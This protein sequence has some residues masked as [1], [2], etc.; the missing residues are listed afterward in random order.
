VEKTWQSEAILVC[1]CNVK[2]LVF[3]HILRFVCWLFVSQKCWGCIAS[4]GHLEHGLFTVQ[5]ILCWLC[6]HE[7]GTCGKNYGLPQN[8]C[9]QSNR[10]PCL[11]KSLLG[12][13]HVCPTCLLAKM[14]R[15]SFLGWSGRTMMAST[16]KAFKVVKC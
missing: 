6:Y 5:I 15:T 10:H 14:V 16:L 8:Q 11:M 3:P 13:L 7:Q 2:V 1:G 12:E 4:G 9:Q